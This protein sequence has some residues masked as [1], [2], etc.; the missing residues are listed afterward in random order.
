MMH[1][2]RVFCLDKIEKFIIKKDDITQG[3]NLV[4]KHSDKVK[5]DTKHHF[6][7]T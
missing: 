5:E 4:K 3:L 2:K 7:Y 6:M 1:S